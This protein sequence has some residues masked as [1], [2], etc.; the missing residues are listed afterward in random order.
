MS[1]TLY[2]ECRCHEPPILSAEV[3]QRLSDLDDI[4][5]YIRNRGALVTAARHCWDFERGWTNVAAYFLSDHQGCVIGI[6]D[7]YGNAHPLDE[8]PEGDHT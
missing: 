2:L 8:P 3:G 6:R 1:T 5:T 7:E 4:R